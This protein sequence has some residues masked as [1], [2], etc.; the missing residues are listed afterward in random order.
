MSNSVRLPWPPKELSPNSRAHW[1]TVNKAKKSMRTSAHILA[2]E[3]KLRA[4]ADGDI[5]IHLT[6]HPPVRRG[7]D[8]DNSLA[9]CKALL[10]G[11]ADALRVNDRRFKPLTPVIADPVEGGC[12]MLAIVQQGEE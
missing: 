4:P 12:V 7:H 3:A 8:R 5:V 2:L 10:D 11:V 1:R 6:M 9:R